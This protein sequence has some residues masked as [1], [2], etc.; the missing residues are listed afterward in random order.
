MNYICFFVAVERGSYSDAKSAL[1]NG[2]NINTAGKGGA[3]LYS[4]NFVVLY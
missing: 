2:A 1:D 3:L 4:K